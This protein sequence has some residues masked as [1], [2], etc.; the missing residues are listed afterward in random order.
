MKKALMVSCEGLGRGGVQAVM[1]GIVRQLRDEYQFDML[2]FTRE[3]RYYDEEFLSYGGK[4]LRLPH[5]EGKNPLLRKLDY[6]CRGSRLYR[7]I[8]QVLQENGPYDVIHCNNGFE[9]GI[10]VRAAQKLG[11]PVRI[12][13]A[14]VC[15]DRENFLRR[16]VNQRYLKWIEKNATGR[17]ACTREAGKVNF[18]ESDFLV[19]GNAYDEARFDPERYPKY[20]KK[21]LLLT[22]IGIYGSNK[23]QEF[24]LEILQQLCRRGV[25]AR[26][27]LVGFGAYKRTLEQRIGQLGLS[28]RVQLLEADT[29]TP[30]LLSRSAAL[31]LPSVKEGFGIV[32][33]EAQAMGVKCYVS[34][35]VPR[36]ADVGGCCFLPLA[37]G[38]QAW[39]DRI[40]ED[41]V[42]GQGAFQTLDCSG[43][44]SQ[45]IMK[46]YRRIYQGEEK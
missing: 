6:P 46:T 42:S 1:M 24:S 13:H 17:L 8:L 23:N 19:V 30:E 5:Y 40:I 35:T 18:Q 12:S 20:T 31:L 3:V 43:F 39:A 33:L 10:C 11:I 21:P 29:D 16:L 15:F 22:Q 45:N 14:H 7:R 36:D 44:S 41:Y 26:L 37:V 28:D 2:L 32:L 9:S 34:D 27:A 4:I 38:P 25:D